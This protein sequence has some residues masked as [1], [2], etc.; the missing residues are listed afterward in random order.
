MERGLKMLMHSV[1]IAFIAYLIMFYG[2]KQTQNIAENRSILL[3]AVV[4][5]YM[6]MFGHKLPNIA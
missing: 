3:G 4:V 6:I 1:I 5:S 2:F